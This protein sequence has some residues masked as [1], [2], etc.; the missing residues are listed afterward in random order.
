VRHAWDPAKDR[1]NW[2]KHG[3]AFGEAVKSF[4][5]P[6]AIIVDDD[7]HPERAILIGTAWKARVLLTVFIDRG[8]DEIR[9]ISARLASRAERRLYEEG[10]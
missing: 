6:L 5:D 3:V 10:D 2:K 4:A 1:S 7:V 9:I 8:D